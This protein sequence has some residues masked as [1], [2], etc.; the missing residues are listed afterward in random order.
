M[1]LESLRKRIMA[2]GKVLPGQIL[3]VDGFLNH[4]VDVSFVDEMGEAFHRLFRNRNVNKILTIE[5][6]GIPIAYATAKA[7]GVPLLFA[8]KA[9]SNNIDETVYVSHVHSYTYD[10]GY[11]IL[12]SKQ[13]MH[14]TDRVLII[15]DF[16]ANGQ[17]IHGLI[18]IVRQ[19]GATLIGAGVAIEKGF[20]K[21]GQAL[22]ESGVD[23]Q[24]LAT[25]ESF[26]G[27]SVVLKVK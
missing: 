25:I 18:D 2:E 1:F 22:R 6:S 10:I 3:K 7:F 8:K 23:I 27:D 24:A 11:D 17:A 20:Q 14:P 26:D 15:D 9:K 12:V 19:S 13:Y 4:L 16:L 5:A 21:G